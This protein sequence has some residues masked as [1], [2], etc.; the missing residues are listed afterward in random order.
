MS[1]QSKHDT[2][3][4]RR[5]DKHYTLFSWSELQSFTP[6]E[7]FN[8]A[9]G[10]LPLLLGISLGFYGVQ[11]DPRKAHLRYFESGMLL[12]AFQRAAQRRVLLHDSYGRTLSLPLS[13]PLAFTV[14]GREK[15]R[16]MTLAQ[17]VHTM[18]L[19]VAVNFAQKD[20]LQ[21][22][23]KGTVN[24]RFFGRLTVVSLYQEPFLCCLPI[25][26]Q[27]G[28]PEEQ[29][30][31]LPCRLNKIGLSVVTSM[32]GHR[33]PR[34]KL[35]ELVRYYMAATHR[36]D[37]SIDPF[38]KE[39]ALIS[40]DVAIANEAD[41][42]DY[43]DED[44]FIIITT[45]QPTRVP[46]TYLSPTLEDRSSNPLYDSTNPSYSRCY[47]ALSQRPPRGHK[48]LAGSSGSED[49]GLSESLSAL[50]L[51]RLS[52]EPPPPPPCRKEQRSALTMTSPEVTDSG[53]TEEN[54]YTYLD[55][56][57]QT[58]GSTDVDCL[59]VDELSIKE[60]SV[61][62]KDLGLDQHC[63]TFQKLRIDGKLLT[64]LDREVLKDELKISELDIV[65]LMMFITEGH[66][67][68]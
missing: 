58:S 47:E 5:P 56:V 24:H 31:P 2:V 6:R 63:E 51:G 20:N 16:T 52:V 45:K 3:S 1:R 21:F 48:R 38:Y 10:E 62:L 53:L 17:I 15:E 50:R 41:I 46:P 66:I 14:K 18:P 36:L 11:T 9:L 35:A 30:V 60:V 49:P 34:E 55:F 29:V 8:G 27:D 37:T 57:G 40:K 67:P 33:N 43:I 7:I 26:Y 22:F 19:P 28:K 23:V 25:G 13:S 4:P 64:K 59:N 44:S 54:E 39:M 61:C 68:R 42:P 65:K 12:F 32:A